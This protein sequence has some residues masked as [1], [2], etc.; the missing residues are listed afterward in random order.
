MA[1]A[2]SCTQSAGK[3]SAQ[4]IAVVQAWAEQI[5][6]HRREVYQCTEKDKAVPDGV[7]KR[8]QS[9]TL[10]EHNARDVDSTTD[11]HLMNP[12]MLTL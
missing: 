6:A 1:L 8:Y 9:I 4:H 12:G 2:Q 10:E 7:C 3:L 11:R 5:V